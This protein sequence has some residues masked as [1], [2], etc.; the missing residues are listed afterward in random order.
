MKLHQK[1]GSVTS[2]A[3]GI[4]HSVPRAAFGFGSMI[5]K[6]KTPAEPVAT[7]TPTTP[8]PPEKTVIPIDYALQQELDDANRRISVAKAALSNTASNI[9]S[10]QRFANMVPANARPAFQMA[11]KRAVRATDDTRT[12]LDLSRRVSIT[13]IPGYEDVSLVPVGGGDVSILPF[14]PSAPPF[15]SERSSGGQASPT[16]VVGFL[17]VRS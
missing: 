12:G 11:I 8:T 2:G 14:F 3:T 15:H 10:L 6:K 9:K 17:P 4:P 7:P 16:K 1:S 5:K 13:P